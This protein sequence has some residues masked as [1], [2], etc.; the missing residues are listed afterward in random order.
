M[1]DYNE[2]SPERVAEQAEPVLFAGM[3]GICDGQG[4]R[5]PEGSGGFVERDAVLSRFESALSGS[6]SNSIDLAY[7]RPGSDPSA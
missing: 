4:K 5:I 7:R 3:V 2:A 6:H 1:N